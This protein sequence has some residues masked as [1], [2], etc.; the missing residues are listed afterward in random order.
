MELLINI[1]Q[2][3]TKSGLKMESLSSKSSRYVAKFEGGA[4]PEGSV[5]LTEEEAIQARFQFVHS[6]K[7]RSEVWPFTYGQILLSAMSGVGG[8]YCNQYYR[9]C[10][11]LRNYAR[12]STYIPVVV[13]PSFLTPLLHSTLI[14]SDILIGKTPCSM[15]VQIKAMALQV[16]I[17]A[18]YPMV[19]APLG[20]F[21]FAERYFT[22]PLPSVKDSP[23][24]LF[25][26]YQRLTAARLPHLGLNMMIQALLAWFITHREI[27]CLHTIISKSKGED[28]DISAK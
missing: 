5:L 8:F 4:V 26:L 20:C 27:T 23:R 19:L 16:S 18:L 22:Y 14:T 3:I 11:N 2:A 10:L 6:W 9:K 28:D 12:M 15:C 25:S 21:Q 7:P 1:F 13:L 17:G 24:E